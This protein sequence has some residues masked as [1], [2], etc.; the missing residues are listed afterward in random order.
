M[1]TDTAKRPTRTDTIWL[2]PYDTRLI[3]LDTSHKSLAEHFLWDDRIHNQLTEESIESVRK[4]GVR[5]NVHIKRDGSDWLAVDGR[6]RIRRARIVF[7]EQTAAGVAVENR[8]KVPCTRVQGTDLE[9][10]LLSRTLNSDRISDTEYQ[11]A[12]YANAAITHYGAT[13]EQLAASYSISVAVL[14]NHMKLLDAAPELIAEMES[15]GVVSATAVGVLVDL[16]RDEQVKELERIKLDASQGKRTTVAE[17][18]DKV[19]AQLGKPR[20]NTPRTRV[21]SATEILTAFSDK[22][23][24]LGANATKAD[25]ETALKDVLSALNKVSKAIT[26]KPVLKLADIGD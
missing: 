21:A 1:A 3:G 13:H 14:R 23:E 16:T 2:S 24:K 4:N 26:G 19:R 6:G 10:M 22:Y 25:Y 7:D 11:I 18:N 12:L 9:L 5:Q 8:I 20:S 15:N 17:L